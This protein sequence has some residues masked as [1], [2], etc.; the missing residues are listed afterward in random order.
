M[1]NIPIKNKGWILTCPSCHVDIFQ[2]INNVYLHDK[3]SAKD[4][5]GINGYPDPREDT[6]AE[7]PNCKINLIKDTGVFS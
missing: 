3:I 7:C 5:K 4:F 1:N 2:L 6:P